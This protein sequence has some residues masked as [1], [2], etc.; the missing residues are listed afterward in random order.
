MDTNEAKRIETTNH[1][2]YQLAT[3]S[4][5][6]FWADMPDLLTRWQVLPFN[7]RGDK[8]MAFGVIKGNFHG[9]QFTMFDFHRRPTVTSVHTR[10]TN[11]KVNELDTITIDSVWVITLPAAMPFFQI[12]SSVESAFDTEQYP[13]PPTPDRKF[14]RWYKLI[15]TDPNAAL[16]VLTPPVMSTMRQLKLHNWSLVGTDLVYAENPFFRTKAD[17]IVDTLGKLAS[18]VGV[19]PVNQPAP[20]QAQPMQPMQ[21]PAPQPYQQPYPPQGYPQQAPPPQYPQYQQP[22]PQQPYPQQPYPP[23]H[24]PQQPYPPQQYPQQP[25]GYP[26][27][28]G[29]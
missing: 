13:E 24:Y 29:Y 10:W 9:L 20:P 12:V 27:Q 18:L 23:Q 5:W 19:L 26:P 8:R 4:G 25:Y 15:D 1:E 22:Y 2:R 7:Q 11:K 16:Q 28:Q 3:S 17:D 6:Q 14:N 21:P